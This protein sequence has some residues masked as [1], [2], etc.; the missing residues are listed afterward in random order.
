MRLVVQPDGAWI[1]G[2]PLQGDVMGADQGRP[3][4]H[5]LYCDDGGHRWAS[6]LLTDE[7]K[8]GTLI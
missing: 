2:R 7:T 8:G 1:C 4:I 6:S 5:T 3:H